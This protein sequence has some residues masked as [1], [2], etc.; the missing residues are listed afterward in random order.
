MFPFNKGL[1]VVQMLE[2]LC[3][4][5]EDFGLHFRCGLQTLEF[6]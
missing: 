1:A 6:T 4:E 5:Q 3:Y 2:T